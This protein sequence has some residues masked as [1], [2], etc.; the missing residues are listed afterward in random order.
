M[1]DD[2]PECVNTCT[3]GE[4]TPITVDSPE[5]NDFHMPCWCCRVDKHSDRHDMMWHEES[6]MYFHKLCLLQRAR[7]KALEIAEAAGTL[8]SS[9]RACIKLSVAGSLLRS[10]RHTVANRA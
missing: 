8:N 2:K 4:C 7:D 9:F 3:A 1:A 10:H 6:E 5:W